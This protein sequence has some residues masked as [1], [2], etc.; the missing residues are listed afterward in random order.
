MIKMTSMKLSS[1]ESKATAPGPV[2]SDRP[3]YPWGLEVRLDEDAL[4]KL[5]IDELPDVD[6]KVS[7]VAKAIVTAVASH[8]DAGADGPRRNVTLQITDLAFVSDVSKAAKV[9]Y[10]KGKG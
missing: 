8:Q 5:K 4:S 7:L 6:A 10:G 2:E 9:L 1:T 3:A